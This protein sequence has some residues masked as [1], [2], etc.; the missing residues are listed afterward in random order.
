MAE[1]TDIAEVIRSIQ[2]E[3]T[4][5]VRGEVALAKQELAAEVTK[6]GVIAGLFAG[7][8]YVV[9]SAAAVLFSAFGFL[10]ALGFQ[11]WFALDLLTALFWGFFTM[12]FAMLLLAALMGFVGSKLPKPGAPSQTMENAKQQVDAVKVAIGAAQTQVATLSL[13]GSAP[14]RHPELD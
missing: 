7:A 11:R 1:Q 12:A 5:I 3:V 14:L 10:W 8:G 9:V 13:S 2:Q 4:T 6:A